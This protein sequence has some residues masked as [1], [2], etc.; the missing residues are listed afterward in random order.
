MLR[1]FHGAL[2]G[3]MMPRL[4]RYAVAFAGVMAASHAAADPLWLYERNALA[5]HTAGT[6]YG[7]PVVSG[8][9]QQLPNFKSTLSLFSSVSG[10]LL[11]ANSFEPELKGAAPG[12]VIGYMFRDGTL[13]PWVGQRV[14]IEFE[15]HA[16]VFQGRES[17]ANGTVPAVSSLS[18]AGIGGTTLV[19]ALLT[20]P[21]CT[22]TEELRFRREGYRLQMRL[23]ADRALDANLAI[24]PSLRV[25]GGQTFDHYRLTQLFENS[26]STAP[27]QINERVRTNE[28]GLAIGL[29]ATWQFAPGWS[30]RAAG[31]AGAVWLRSRLDGDQCFVA[32]S[33]AGTVCGP[34]LPNFLGSSVTDKRSTVG[35]RGTVGLGLSADFRYAVAT[36]GGYFRYDSQIPGVDNPQFSSQTVTGFSVAGGNPAARVRFS[37]GIAYGGYLRFVIPLQGL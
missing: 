17:G 7:G 11:F 24:T 26:I 16:L 36:V 10:P 25:F 15:A 31:S 13:P 3:D 9:V 27:G 29:A 37:G 2:G 8:G 35:F 4:I 6:I 14:R 34:S 28:F 33:T 32:G 18:V 22:Y 21:G 12:G 30:I 19:A 1:G 23:A 20:C 5:P